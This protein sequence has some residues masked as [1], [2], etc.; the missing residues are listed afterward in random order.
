MINISNTLVVEDENISNGY[1]SP[2]IK[3]SFFFLLLLLLIQLAIVPI[4]V[5]SL[6]LFSVPIISKMPRVWEMGKAFLHTIHSSTP[7]FRYKYI[8]DT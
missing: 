7:V 1:R 8:V 2:L 3:V 4:L 5:F 6:L